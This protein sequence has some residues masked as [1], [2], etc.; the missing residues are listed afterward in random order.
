MGIPGIAVNAPVL[1][2]LIRIYGEVHSDIRTIYLVYY[3]LGIYIGKRRASPA[4][5]ILEIDPLLVLTGIGQLRK[6]V[7]RI[8]I[9]A[10]AL[11]VF[12]IAQSDGKSE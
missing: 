8:V 6:P 12:V 4:V 3:G 2:A 11:Y 1:A 5:V 10:S 9:G 7:G